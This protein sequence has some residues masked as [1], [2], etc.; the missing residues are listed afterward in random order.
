MEE[1]KEKKV[2]DGRRKGKGVE[3]E[4]GMEGTYHT[5]KS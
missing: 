2:E 5:F 4:G 3:G 1:E